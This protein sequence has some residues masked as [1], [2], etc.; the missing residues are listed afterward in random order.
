MKLVFESISEEHRK[1]VI[2][3]F[4]HYIL[5]T[6]AAYREEKVHYDFFDNFLN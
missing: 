3:I 4:N 6:T 5:N 2:D 1:S